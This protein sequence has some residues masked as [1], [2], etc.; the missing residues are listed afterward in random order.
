MDVGQTLSSSD[1]K[2]VEAVNQ[3]AQQVRTPGAM[4][5]KIHTQFQQ[6]T[7]WNQ[8]IMDR[9]WSQKCP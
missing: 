4:H 2:G 8:T 7:F 1:R 6:C 3:Q 5:G 9:W